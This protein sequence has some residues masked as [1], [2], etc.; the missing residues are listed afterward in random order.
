MASFNV[1]LQGKNNLV[2]VL[3]KHLR[4]F[5][6]GLLFYEESMCELK[7]DSFLTFKSVVHVDNE[8]VDS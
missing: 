6:R 7:V 5:E 1:K 3:F 4:T 8:S 2:H